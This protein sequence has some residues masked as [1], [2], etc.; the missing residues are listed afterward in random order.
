[1]DKPL[2]SRVALVA[3]ATRGAGRGI[4]VELGAAGA[5]VYCTGRT[6]RTQPSP[7][8]RPETIEETAELVTAAG[9]RGIAIRVDHMEIEEVRGLVERIDAE[10]HGR[11]DIL[12]NDVWG[13]QPL[14]DWDKPVFWEHSLDDG[15]RMYRNAVETHIIT[16]WHAAPLMARRGS[17]LIVEITDGD[18]PLDYRPLF[19][20]LCKKAPMRMA[21]T[22]GEDLKTFGVTAVPLTPGF[23]RSEE[24]LEKDQG[25]R[26]EEQWQATVWRDR[27]DRA[28][29]I[30]ESYVSETPHFVGRAVVAL[31]TDP[32]VE[33]W[34]GKVLSSWALATEYGFTD[35]NGTRPL[36]GNGVVEIL[37]DTGHVIDTEDYTDVPPWSLANE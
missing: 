8:N 3:G 1:M 26:S 37:D 15:L 35:L 36:W 10:Q 4:A 24:M 5:T 22:M 31:A 12:V 11:L 25:C 2:E 28:A 18:D 21:Y 27:A 34:R 29:R 33:R 7:L 6:T 16:A 30:R 32:H 13:G 14:A 20:D 23:L 9:G 17:G 19:Y